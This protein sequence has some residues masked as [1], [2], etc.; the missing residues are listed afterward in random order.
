MK[1][2]AILSKKGGVGKTTLS[3]L[4]AIGG[5]WNNKQMALLHTDDRE[6]IACDRPY[7]YFD[8]RKDKTLQ[9]TANRIVSSG[10]DG[11]MIIDSGGNRTKTDAWIAKS[12]NL[13]LMPLTLSAEDVKETLLHAKELKDAGAEV[14]Y[15]INQMPAA[16]SL[17]AYDNDLIDRLNSSDFFTIPKV[18]A[19]RML[20]DDDHKGFKTPTTAV[21]NAARHFYR[22]LQSRLEL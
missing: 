17:S 21:N 7:A 14:Q 8:C 9:E 20:L 19:A 13:V 2:V 12:V 11:L 18:K 6:P 10:Q 4:L 16:S 3:H 15:L 5:V 1:S 22:Q